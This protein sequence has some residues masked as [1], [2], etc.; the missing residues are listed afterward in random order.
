MMDEAVDA[1]YRDGATSDPILKSIFMAE[2]INQRNGGGL[3]KPWELES[4]PEDWLDAYYSLHGANGRKM[5]KQR[6][7]KYH[8]E[9][10]RVNKYR[11]Y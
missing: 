6:M 10:R 7:E 4:V 8:D 9:F 3:V 5:E 2:A 1:A 11:S